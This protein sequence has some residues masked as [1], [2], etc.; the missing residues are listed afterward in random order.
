[1]N[2]QEIKPLYEGPPI[3]LRPL[4]PE[5]IKEFAARPGVRQVA[6]ENF[7]MTAHHNQEI[8]IAFMNLLRDAHLYKWN[9]ETIN[10][11]IDGLLAAVMDEGEEDECFE[12]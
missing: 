2:F 9:I 12:E 3:R 10:A 5:E 6:V 4:K 8:T 11:I 7:L 1:M